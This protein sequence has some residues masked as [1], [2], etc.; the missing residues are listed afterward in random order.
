MHEVRHY[1]EDRSLFVRGPVLK[2]GA[3]GPVLGDMPGVFPGA[4]CRALPALR[5]PVLQR[6]EVATRRT[7]GCVCKVDGGQSLVGGDEIMQCIV[8]RRLYLFRDRTSMQVFSHVVPSNM[9]H[10][11]LRARAC[12]VVQSILGR[13]SSCTRIRV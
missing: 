1:P 9:R 6:V 3:D 5:Y 10:M 2:G 12:P 11:Q 13:L 4:D 8:L 7:S